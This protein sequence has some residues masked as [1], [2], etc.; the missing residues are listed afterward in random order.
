VIP[1]GKHFRV[2]RGDPV[3]AGEALVDGPLVPKDILRINGEEAVQQ[4]LMREIQNVYRSQNVTINDKHIEIIIA[5]MLRNIEVVD[6]GDTDILPGTVI[7]KFKFRA[8]NQE[9]VKL[10]KK[11]ATAE[12]LLL[13]ITKASLHSESFISAASFQETTKVLTEAALAGKTDLLVGLKEN[14]ILGHLVPAGTG[15]KEY[16]S[17]TVQKLAEP[18]ARPK[19]REPVVRVVVDEDVEADEEAESA[20]TERASVAISDGTDGDSDDES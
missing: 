18:V 12:P 14:V 19:R 10:G 9:T 5:Q 3:R 6:S 7:D 15:F 13:G 16:L 1:H 11:P 8:I 4:Y 20:I 2:H 17:Q